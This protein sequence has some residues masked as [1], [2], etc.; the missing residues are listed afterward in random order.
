MMRTCP[1]T[2]TLL[3]ALALLALIGSV[4]RPAQTD[5][6]HDRDSDGR[7]R[8]AF[9]TNRTGEPEIFV[10]RED[11]SDPVNLTNNP[12]S[13]D[14][15]PAWS[16]DG[17]RL[18]FVRGSGFARELFV[19]NADG[20]NQ[21]R[22]T[23]NT[24]ADLASA[25]SPDGTQIAVV[26]FGPDFNFDIWVIDVS[27]TG[28]ELRLTSGPGFDAF[29]S[30]SRNGRWI[31]YSTDEEGFNA[32]YKVR[33]DGS[34]PARRLTPPE[35]QAGAA[36]WS[37]DGKEIAFVDN[38]CGTC[39]ESDV[40]VMDLRD[41]DLRQL[42]DTP[43]NELLPSW[44][45]DGERITYESSLIV[46]DALL[47]PDVFVIDVEDGT[48]ENLTTALTFSTSRPRSIESGT[49]GAMTNTS[50]VIGTRVERQVW[51]RPVRGVQGALRGIL[52]PRTADKPHGWRDV[53]VAAWTATC[54]PS[55]C[56]SEQHSPSLRRGRP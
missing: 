29:P 9:A 49:T 50:G 20:T 48:A 37:P 28:P 27:G 40:W 12:T 45:S 38:L 32:V 34:G 25:W 41:G 39:D 36:S 11:G 19:M 8:I 44:S 53:M 6:H 21:T 1:K 54:G 51:N 3:P 52:P 7:R 30:W 16:P 31:L 42:T 24:V 26:R 17:S 18:T 15:W 55:A 2:Q 47:A 23:T 46:G 14:T 35:M 10:M 33:A 4:E 56:R 5:D 43:D 22:L 13:P